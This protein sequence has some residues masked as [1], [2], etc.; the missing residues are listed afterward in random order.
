MKGYP[1]NIA[2]R[3]D[4]EFLL[5]DPEFKARALKDLKRVVDLADDTVQKVKSYDLD[6]A[7]KMINVVTEEVPAPA[8]KWKQLGFESRKKAA[9]LHAAVVAVSVVEDPIAKGGI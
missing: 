1:K 7:G 8:P 3:A 4:L 5:A 9:D 2:T 6:A